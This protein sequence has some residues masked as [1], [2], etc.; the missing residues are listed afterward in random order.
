MNNTQEITSFAAATLLGDMRTAILDEIRNQQKPWQQAS[1]SEQQAVIDRC[2]AKAE[3]ILERAT[4]IIASEGRQVVEGEIESV[5]IKDGVKAVIKIRNDK[6]NRDLVGDAQGQQVLI[7]CAGA[8]A[9]SGERSPEKPAPDQ[10]DMLDSAKAY[11]D[12][13]GAGMEKTEV[14]T[15]S[16]HSQVIDAEHEDITNEAE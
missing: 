7:V 9:F 15:L 11:T 14:F 12:E 13:D 3:H 10:G 2:T 4:H 8:E 16:D 6:H 1:E 5:A